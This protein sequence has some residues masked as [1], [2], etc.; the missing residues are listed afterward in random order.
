M[1]RILYG[2]A[3]A[4]A[5]VVIPTIATAQAKAPAPQPRADP[6]LRSGLG[7]NAHGGFGFHG[8]GGL[9][10]DACGVIGLYGLDEFAASSC[11]GSG[12][13][14]LFTFGGFLSYTKPVGTN[15]VQ[16][17]GGYHFT[18]RNEIRI[19]AEGVLPDFGAD[20]TLAGGFRYTAQAFYGGA[21]VEFG[22]VY[23]GG[24]AGLVR[25]SGDAFVSASLR[26]DNV[27]YDQIDE[28]QPRS[29]TSPM[30]GVRGMYSFQPGI[31]AYADWYTYGLGDY[32]DVLA[33][34][35]TPLPLPM[36]APLK[37]PARDRVLTFGV[38]IDLYTFFK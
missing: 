37:L 14:K 34:A 19:D 9:I 24:I 25:Y 31:R 32:Y 23:V 11:D 35:G 13:R 3:A 36:P 2:L 15:R 4:M 22:D 1:L 8:S 26:F 17:Q 28:E 18:P 27:L 21:G 29:G 38:A 12:G 30:F 7:I 16:F 10:D 20:F 33:G 6:A 5:A